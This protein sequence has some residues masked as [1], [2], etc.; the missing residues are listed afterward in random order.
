MSSAPLIVV[1]LAALLIGA[2]LLVRGA[3]RSL[4]TS[5]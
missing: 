1:G 5:A 2:D 4:H 3:A